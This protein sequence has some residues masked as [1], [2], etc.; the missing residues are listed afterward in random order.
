MNKYYVMTEKSLVIL[1][2]ITILA[3]LST[4]WSSFVYVTLAAL[5]LLVTSFEGVCLDPNKG[6]QRTTRKTKP[7]PE[8]EPENKH[9]SYSW[10]GELLL[11]HFTHSPPKFTDRIKIADGTK[12]RPIEMTWPK[13]SEELNTI[14]YHVELVEDA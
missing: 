9:V 7:E 6:K 5:C 3:G 10:Q 13:K 14:N 11:E 2:L 12:L 4:M 1:L 8:I